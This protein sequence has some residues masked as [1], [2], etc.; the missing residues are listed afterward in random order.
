M[1]SAL[2]VMGGDLGPRA[3]VDGAYLYLKEAP[4]DDHIVLVGDQ[5]LIKERLK[6]IPEK[7]HKRFS[8]VHAPDNIGMNESPTEAFKKKTNASMVVGLKLHAS[9]Q[10][11]AFV[12]AGHTGA[13]MAGSLLT[14]KRIPGVK[15]PA[16]G[17]FLP[18]E[19]GMVFLID[20]GA[21]VDSKPIHLLQFALMASIFVGEV[22]QQK[23]LKIGLL[24]I[25]E[26]EKKGNALTLAAHQLFKE[27]LPNFYGNVE[28][29]DILK[30]K[31]DIIVCDGFVGNALLKM[32]ESVMGVI[33]KAIKRNI[34]AN[35][36][37]NLGALLV[38]PAFSELKR[39]YD[40]QEYGGVPLLGVDGI[41]IICH[42]NSTARA[43]KNALRVAHEM[44]S[45]QVN[46]RIAE[47]LRE[48]E[49]NNA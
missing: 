27:N 37:T 33:V 8:I 39:S 17:S 35:L 34:G 32:A 46:K 25:G 7:Y 44:S 47:K 36:F 28:G 26:E 5:D 29:R 10:A 3:T 13:Q 21:N 19:K 12:S 20:V 4:K 43:I 24:S 48:K 22:F 30:G 18:S 49:L 15:R 11:D 45:H 6:H 41:S 42:G 14:L 38:K 40:Y 2:D 9:G 16:I 1:R 23:D 31:T